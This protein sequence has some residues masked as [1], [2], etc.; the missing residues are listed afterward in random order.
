ME[1]LVIK[2]VEVLMIAL[3]ISV[4]AQQ[5]IEGILKTFKIESIIPIKL[6]VIVV[7]CWL[8]YYV[9]YFMM[10]IIEWQHLITILILVF[11]GAEV[12]NSII[13]KFK[14]L[15]SNTLSE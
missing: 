10:T 2:L 6:T 8:V 4:F 11:A 12:I 7:E 5:V 15:K 9:A 14:D 3:V 13:K 1:N